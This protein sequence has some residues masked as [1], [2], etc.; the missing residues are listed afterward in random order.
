MIHLK[1]ATTAAALGSIICLLGA[2]THMHINYSKLHFFRKFKCLA[3]HHLA[4]FLGFGSLS[5]SAHQIHIALPIN[6]FLDAAVDPALLPWPQDLSFG[7]IRSFSV[8]GA[9]GA[10]FLGIQAAHHLYLAVALCL[11]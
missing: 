6:R 7:N 8:N 2:Y 9:T 10:V 4:I 1:Y 5:W 11:Q 3:I